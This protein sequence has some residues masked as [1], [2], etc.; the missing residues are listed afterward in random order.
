MG[1]WILTASVITLLAAVPTAI[2][3]ASH[4]K[5]VA[6]KERWYDAF[7]RIS[8]TIGFTAWLICLILLLSAFVRHA[9]VLRRLDE[10]APA[11]PN[12]AFIENA[13]LWQQLVRLSW[14]GVGLTIY[15]FVFPFVAFGLAF[16]TGDW[17]PRPSG[18]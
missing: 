7:F 1:R 16:I 15:F 4:L 12:E 14:Y 10:A 18:W 5:W 3:M 9:L 13:R 6:D 17:G 8:F 11:S 2:F